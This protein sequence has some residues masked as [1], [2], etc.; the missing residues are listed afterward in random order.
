MRPLVIA[1]LLGFVAL[2][3]VAYGCAAAVAI[4]ADAEDWEPFRLA[5]GPVLALEFERT[6]AGS[7]TT[8]GPGLALAGLAGGVLNVAVAGL[9]RR[10]RV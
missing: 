4:L 9:L 7:A 2:A 8:F 3:L 1:F 6:G 10:R 5:L